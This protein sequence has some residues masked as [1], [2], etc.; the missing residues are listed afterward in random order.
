MTATHPTLHLDPAHIGPGANPRKRFR[1]APLEALRDSIA[2]HG[3]IQPI[4]VRPAGENRYT[5]VAGERRWRCA[6]ALALPAV[7]AILRTDLTDADARELAL[8]EN[9]QRQDLDPVE[10][11]EALRDL[12]QLRRWNDVI[13]ITG[14]NKDHIARA[15]K[16]LEAPE[17]V[18]LAVAEGHLRPSVG[19]A[20]GSI[21]SPKLQNTASQDILS[22]P[23]LPA[24]QAIAHLQKTYLLPLRLAPFDVLD[25][26]L[27]PDAGPCLGC[28]HT[29]TAAAA[30]ADRRLN[31]ATYCLSPACHQAKTNAHREAIYRAAAAAG[32]PI[33]TPDQAADAHS[34]ASPLL[35]LAE[36][37]P[38]G[39]LKP[40]EAA[41]KRLP[42]WGDLARNPAGEWLVTP[43]IH[44]PEG[45]RE[46]EY[47]AHENHLITAG[48]RLLGRDIFRSRPV[49]D[50]SVRARGARDAKTE[51]ERRLHE[52]LN[53]ITRAAV[54]DLTGHLLLSH[55][56]ALLPHL[57][58]AADPWTLGFFAARV[59]IDPTSAP[60]DDERIAAILAYATSSGPRSRA[61]AAL[62]NE[63]LALLLAIILSP[64]EAPLADSPILADLLALNPPA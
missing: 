62:G 45:A 5:I 49:S 54:A 15:L 26:A 42:K 35:P 29:S 24:G 2:E 50:R 63:L 31:A 52:A 4:V 43:S 27:V 23:G 16:L 30:R 40:A 55:R 53:A 60:S 36:E 46:P 17:A 12:L 34:W 37:I 20:L 41:K 3:I 58:A 33:L 13:R 14:R 28:P 32:H 48:R 6:V 56:A 47:F 11:A 59:G 8:V 21:R 9:L 64:L 51:D 7:P 44:L 57:L 61:A 10:E 39:F 19:A 1:P 38:A 18:L 25:P 22:R